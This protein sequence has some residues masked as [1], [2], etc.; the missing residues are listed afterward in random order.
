MQFMISDLYSFT[1]ILK[2]KSHT[3]LYVTLRPCVFTFTLILAL[4]LPGY[5]IKDKKTSKP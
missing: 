5:A 4:L 3:Y 2:D 1:P